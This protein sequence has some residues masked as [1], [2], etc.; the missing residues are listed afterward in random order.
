MQK[1][2]LFLLLISAVV[3]FLMTS[4]AVQMKRLHSHLNRKLKHK[5]HVRDMHPA[6]V[7]TFYKNSS[8]SSRHS[9][10]DYSDKFGFNV[11]TGLLNAMNGNKGMLRSSR[12]KR[13][14]YAWPPDS[15]FIA[16]FCLEIPLYAPEGVNIPLLLEVT[17]DID[18]PN[19]TES[20]I[21][22]RKNDQRLSFFGT[23]EA[24][25]NRFGLKGESCVLRAICER[26][27]SEIVT[28]S[29]IG[30][31]LS[32]VLAVST[33]QS[34]SIFMEQYKEAEYHGKSIGDCSARY[35]DCPVS[36]FHFLD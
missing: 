13:S 34:T 7:R 20:I 10:Q 6:I 12:D 5:K 18:L 14:T 21:E 19:V 11:N 4:H 26:A 29:L 16:Q 24:M 23:M 27:E 2:K 15:L 28:K 31:V 35:S 17:Y 32:L 1:L 3:I 36:I 30:E 8:V 22:A 9:S 25:F 33:S